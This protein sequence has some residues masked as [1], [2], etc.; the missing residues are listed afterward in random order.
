MF[1]IAVLGSVGFGGGFVQ[2]STIATWCL[3]AWAVSWLIVASAA[4]ILALS[5]SLRN[6]V[7]VGVL[8]FRHPRQWFEVA[9]F[10]CILGVVMAVVALLLGYFELATI[11]IIGNVIIACLASFSFASTIGYVMTEL[12]HRQTF[13]RAKECVNFFYPLVLA[14]TVVMCFVFAFPGNVNDPNSYVPAIML[15]VGICLVGV[16]L[17]TL[18]NRWR[19]SA[20]PSIENTR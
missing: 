11:D 15:L 6:I 19:G 10:T 2:G 18:R 17:V 16:L 1:I 8:G 13:G 3:R 14:A 9:R 4:A 12:G 7:R 20:P 5:D